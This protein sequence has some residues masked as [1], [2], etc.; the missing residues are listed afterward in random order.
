MIESVAGVVE[1]SAFGADKSA[2][3]LVLEVPHG[4]TKRAHFD[5]LRAQLKGGSFP[6]DLVDFF[7][8][9]TDVGAPEV[10]YA[11]AHEIVK[12]DATQRV[13]VLHCQIPR[14]FIDCNRV[15]DASTRP[16]ASTPG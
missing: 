13:L 9:N 12:R 8:V 7:F 5:A 2:P 4:A 15:I 3:D 11:L 6:D 10:A 1:V 16:S 14:T